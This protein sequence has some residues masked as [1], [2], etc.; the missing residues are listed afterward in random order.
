MQ[1]RWSTNEA[2]KHTRQKSRRT[3][4]HRHQIFHIVRKLFSFR[5]CAC[6]RLCA[7]RAI[8]RRSHNNFYDENKQHGAKDEEE[9]QRRSAV[10]LTIRAADDAQ[11][12]D[13]W[14]AVPVA[15]ATEAAR[16]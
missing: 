13:A 9:H 14:L 6:R 3:W 5:H 2:V 11:A 1:T 12:A 16:V 8:V 4:D 7:L 15:F 10:C